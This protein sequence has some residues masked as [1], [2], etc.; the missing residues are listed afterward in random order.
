MII[1]KRLLFFCINYSMLILVQIGEIYLK[2]LKILSSLCDKLFGSFI[3]FGVSVTS[4]SC[5][6]M[7]VRIAEPTLNNSLGVK[8]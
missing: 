1:Q 7:R 4:P 8:G 6:T 5:P 2:A 3:V